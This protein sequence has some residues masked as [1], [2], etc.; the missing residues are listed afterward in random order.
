MYYSNRNSD[1]SAVYRPFFLPS[2]SDWIYLVMATRNKLHFP[3][4]PAPHW[5]HVAKFKS[6]GFNWKWY[7]QLPVNIL[8][9]NGLPLCW[10][11]PFSPDGAAILDSDVEVMLRMA[12]PEQEEPGSADTG[13]PPS[14]AP[15]HY[16]ALRWR[17]RK[18]PLLKPSVF[19]VFSH[20]DL[21]LNS[22]TMKEK[23]KGSMSD[24]DRNSWM[25]KGASGLAPHRK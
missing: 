18:S 14:P 2:Y 16:R 4:F 3:V 1:L 7:I 8:K 12:E 22:I 23:M 9:N 10:F 21:I 19:G 6:R 5:G 25:E 20:S 15:L 17:G 24:Y 11:S 13:E